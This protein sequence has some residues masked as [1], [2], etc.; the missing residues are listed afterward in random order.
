MPQFFID[1]KFSKGSEVE[2]RGGD[3]RHIAQVLR[4]K[5]GDWIVLSD[6]D[7][8]SFRAVIKESSPT[9]VIAAVESKLTRHDGKIPPTL[10]LALIKADRFEWAIEKAVELGSSRIVPFKS[11]RT[12]PQYAAGAS[13]RKIE[14]WQKIALAAAKQSGLPFRPVVED[15][16]EF[17]EIVRTAK[18]PVLFFEGEEKNDIRSLWNLRSAAQS[19]TL[20]I[21]P[22]GGFTGEEVALAKKS[23]AVTASLGTQILR[24]ETAAIA[25]LAIW[26]YE[27]GNMDICR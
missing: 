14:R 1:K 17:A 21:G 22:E 12:V 3:A 13:A 27:L 5:S 16:R 9:G 4:L 11:A 24:V 6:G 25:A 19:D 15:S 18:N 26:Q 20:I 8:N 10:A 23:G 7:G 2:I